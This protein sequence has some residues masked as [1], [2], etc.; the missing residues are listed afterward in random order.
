MEQVALNIFHYEI[1]EVDLHERGLLLLGQ[2]LEW[3]SADV[4]D[5]DDVPIKETQ[6]SYGPVSTTCSSSSLYALAVKV[7]VEEIFGTSSLYDGRGNFDVADPHP[8]HFVI[9]KYCLPL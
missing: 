5:C 3:P 8:P 2:G 9:S 7:N 1:V 6:G 4:L